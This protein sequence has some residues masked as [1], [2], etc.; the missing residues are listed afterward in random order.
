MKGRLSMGAESL[1]CGLAVAAIERRNKMIPV[2]FIVPR[3]LGKAQQVFG[4][5]LET[6][7]DELNGVLVA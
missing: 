2:Q 1:N 5:E 7:I 4:T 3:G 6:L